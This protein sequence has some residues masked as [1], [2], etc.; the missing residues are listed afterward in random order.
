MQYI[1]FIGL[2][3]YLFLPSRSSALVCVL[4]VVFALNLTSLVGKTCPSPDRGLIY[5]LG[6]VWGFFCPGES[7]L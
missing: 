5:G 2:T 1:T 6:N 3:P 7:S 4:V